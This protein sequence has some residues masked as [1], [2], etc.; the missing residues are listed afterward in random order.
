LIQHGKSKENKIKIHK[1]LF[2][3]ARR[4][5]R[6]KEKPPHECFCFNKESLVKREIKAHL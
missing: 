3:L 4:V 5:T 6:K 1:K 2:D